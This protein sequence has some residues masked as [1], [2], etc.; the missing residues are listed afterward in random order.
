[1]YASLRQLPQQIGLRTIVCP[2]HD[3]NND[4]AT[5][6]ES[7]CRD[8]QLL[9]RIVDPSLPMT[10]EEFLS[11]K[12]GIDA[13]IGDAENSE[14]ICGLIRGVGGDAAQVSV[15]LHKDQLKGFFAEH[16]DSLIIDVREPHEFSFEQ[17]WEALGFDS[18]PEN[19]PLTRLAG[20][21]PKL[22][23]LSRHGLED[24]I[25]LCRSGRRSGKAAQ[26]ARRI[27]IRN[28]RHIAGGLALNVDHT[29]G[30]EV[31]EPGY[32]I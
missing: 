3:Y 13:G 5:T 26:I 11:T 22:L 30:N 31:M 28:A 19:I 4:F 6:L 2:T 24:I 23:E 18:P 27:G 16:R 25:F 12:P 7:E 10:L 32:M 15:D 17:H 20:Y 14:L 29:C 8:N 9:Q 1:M 21:L